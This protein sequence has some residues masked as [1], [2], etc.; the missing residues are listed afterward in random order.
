MKKEVK[1]KVKD[2]QKAIDLSN[3]DVI[4]SLTRHDK[5]HYILTIEN[6]ISDESVVD[7]YLA[8]LK[9]ELS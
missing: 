8:L 1:I 3:V 7:D 5:E 2:K 4:T 6:R 9:A